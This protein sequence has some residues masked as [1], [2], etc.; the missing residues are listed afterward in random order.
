MASMASANRSWP[1][2]MDVN[3]QLLNGRSPRRSGLVR[4]PP[5]AAVTMTGIF[6]ATDIAAE[7]GP[8]E[9]PFLR[10]KRKVDVDHHQCDHR[11]RGEAVHGIDHTP[12]AGVE[13]IGV[14]PPQR[15]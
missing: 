11:H 9:P 3:P 7:H 1:S 5:A 10:P 13:P 15:R 4:H 12:G 8:R 2:A 14:A 6:L